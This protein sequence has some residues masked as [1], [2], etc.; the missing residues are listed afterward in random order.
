MQ[1]TAHPQEKR[2]SVFR[3]VP[4]YTYT[5]EPFVMAQAYD[6]SVPLDVY[7][8]RIDRYN[9][10]EWARRNPMLNATDADGRNLYR[11]SESGNLIRC[12]PLSK[13]LKRKIKA[14]DG[15]CVWCGSI[16]RLEVDH[17]VRYI[18]GGGNDESNLQTLC[19]PCHA[20]KG[21]R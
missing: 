16:D 8:F 21:G 3:Y 1:S 6:G 2:V 20:S 14:R 10:I 12:F 9:K 11:L 13:A 7:R 5:D 15:R 17:I 4:S 18:D 19:H